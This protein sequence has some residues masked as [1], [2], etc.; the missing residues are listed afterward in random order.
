MDDGVEAEDGDADDEARD[1]GENE[2][3]AAL[4]AQLG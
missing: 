1:E 4:L 2:G 3:E